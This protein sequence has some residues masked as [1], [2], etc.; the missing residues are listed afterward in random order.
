MLNPKIPCSSI[1]Y[2]TINR[3]Y[4]DRPG[5][6]FRFKT[7]H[8]RLFLECSVFFKEKPTAGTLFN[9]VIAQTELNLPSFRCELYSSNRPSFFISHRLIVPKKKQPGLSFGRLVGKTFC[10]VSICFS[11]LN[12]WIH[13]FDLTRLLTLDQNLHARPPHCFRECLFKLYYI[14][15]QRNTT[16]VQL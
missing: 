10:A 13:R 8:A 4:H 12:L 11:G 1:F 2:W 15:V 16:S 5:W 7:V 14:Y 6:L 3:F 9:A